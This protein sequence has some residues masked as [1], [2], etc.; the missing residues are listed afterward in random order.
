MAEVEPQFRVGLSII[1]H[2]HKTSGKEH[3]SLS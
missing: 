1:Q 3:S 2:T